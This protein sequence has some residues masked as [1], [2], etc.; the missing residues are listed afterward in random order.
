MNYGCACEVFRVG[1]FYKFFTFVMRSIESCEIMVHDLL[2][3]LL[4]SRP[5]LTG[6]L[7][8]SMAKCPSRLSISDFFNIE[9]GRGPAT[10][11]ADFNFVVGTTKLPR[12]CIYNC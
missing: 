11:S 1:V 3:I 9:S 7:P 2:Q 5:Q 10:T 8:W 4:I 12:N 6:D